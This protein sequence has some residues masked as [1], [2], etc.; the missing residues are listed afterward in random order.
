[1]RLKVLLIGIVAV[2]ALEVFSG[3]SAVLLRPANVSGGEATSSVVTEEQALRSHLP[4]DDSVSPR[5]RLLH[6]LAAPDRSGDDLSSLQIEQTEWGHVAAQSRLEDE[7]PT[8]EQPAA[9]PRLEFLCTF[10]S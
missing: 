4:Q 3:Y 7:K 5:P 8:S 1:M 2:A 9:K 6:P 10:L